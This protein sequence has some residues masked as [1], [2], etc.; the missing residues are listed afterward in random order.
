MNTDFH[1]FA[2]R[3]VCE[4]RVPPLGVSSYDQVVGAAASFNP[5]RH[6]GTR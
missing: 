6:G 1:I 4:G 2:A 5:T 3:G